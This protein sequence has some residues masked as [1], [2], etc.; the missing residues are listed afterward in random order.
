MATGGHALMLIDGAG[1]LG[2]V[3]HVY[4]S[5]F[6]FVASRFMTV[7]VGWRFGEKR[8]SPEEGWPE[9]GVTGPTPWCHGPAH[10]R[11]AGN[12]LHIWW[13]E[14]PLSDRSFSRVAS[15]LSAD[16]RARADRF[17]FERHRQNYVGAH[18]ILRD[19]LSRYLDRPPADFIFT[20]GPYGKPALENA[21]LR[22]NLSHC[23]DRV[24]IAV[25]R[26]GE[27]GVDVERL[28]PIQGMEGMV[29]Q[30]FAPGEIREIFALPPPLR[31]I[32]FFTAWTRKEAY[33]KA[34]GD[35]LTRPF[36][37]FEVS[38]APG[39]PPGLRND[40]PLRNDAPKCSFRD[41]DLGPDHLGVAA[42]LGQIGQMRQMPWPG[43][44]ESQEP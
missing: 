23:E 1:I 29:T 31:Q 20:H 19:V 24:L 42:V 22:F 8:D 21:E 34:H 3:T 41:I 14:L 10:P 25:I 32:G 15:T 6:C 7:A 28:R 39:S 43:P 44:L 18:G 30:F 35:G 2:Q 26:A 13:A 17:L 16:E 4:N 40:E 36:D 38:A 27:V 33:V 11:L 5:P 12:E 37:S 9:E